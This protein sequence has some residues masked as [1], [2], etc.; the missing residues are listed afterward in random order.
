MI[1]KRCLD[2]NGFNNYRP[3]SYLCFIAKIQEKLVMSKFLPTRNIYNIFQS[4]YRPGHS[5]E[6]ALLKVVND[7]FLHLSKGSMSVLALHD[8]SSAFDTIDHSIHI[9]RIHTDFVFTDAVLQWLSSYLIDRTQYVSLS[10]QCSV[11][12]PVHSSVSQA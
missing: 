12:A 8:F 11:F 4:A 9:H 7:L 6:T 3:L 1:K 2:H 5:T 10:N